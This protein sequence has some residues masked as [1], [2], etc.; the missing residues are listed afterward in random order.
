MNNLKDQVF[1]YTRKNPQVETLVDD[2]IC[3]VAII[4]GGMAGL[5]AAQKCKSFGMNVVVLEKTFCGGGASGKSSGFITP[6][7]E[8]ELSTLIKHYGK[9]KS[10]RMWDFVCDGVEVM[11]DTINEYNLECDY[12][13]QDSL[14]IANSDSEIESVVGEHDARESLG[15]ESKLYNKNQVHEIIGSS[16]YYGAVRYPGTFGVD[17][18]LYCQGLARKLKSM[19]VSIYE[20]TPVIRIENSQVVTTKGRVKAKYIILALDHFAPDLNFLNNSVYHAQTFLSVSKQ[21]TNEQVKSIFPKDKF[22]VW[23]TDFI[24]QYYRITGD[25]RLLLGG[26]DVLY[27]YSKNEVH[28]FS[29]MSDKLKNYTRR[30]FPQVKIEFE[31]FWP[32]LIGVSKDFLPLAGKV[33]NRENIFYVSACAGLPWAAQ[34]GT[35]LAEKIKN[36]RSDF[37]DIFNENRKYP[38][39][40]ILQKVIGKR[41]A[42]ALSHGFAKYFD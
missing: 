42:F 11:R 8:L 3:D 29:R 37:D 39:P 31:Y 36:D 24:Y 34:I 22:M 32:G 26:A 4:G 23:D 20:S 17:A 12:Q 28:N 16:D 21:L 1:W 25:N 41:N 14:Y 7:S 35:Y 18:Y 9:E 2:R 13:I 38:V 15:Y 19:G 5:S 6:D 33:P 10:K 30:K 27:T 40:L